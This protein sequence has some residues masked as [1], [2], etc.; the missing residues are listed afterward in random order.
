MKSSSEA[1]FVCTDDSISDEVQKV[2]AKG[3]NTFLDI[4]LQKKN[5]LYKKLFRFRE[6]G[7]PVYVHR[8]CRKKLTDK[9]VKRCNDENSS[10]LETPKK[11]RSCSTETLFS[12]KSCCFFLCKKSREVSLLT[13]ECSP[14]PNIVE[15]KRKFVASKSCCGS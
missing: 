7:S 3:F 9:R 4:C 12:W 10:V 6:A 15:Q 8:C 11:L 13:R 1:C 14:G 2:G 5:P